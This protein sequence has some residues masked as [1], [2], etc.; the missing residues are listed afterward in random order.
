MK[1]LSVRGNPLIGLYAKVSENFAVIGVSD[2]KLESSLRETLGVDVVSTTVAG[3]ELVGAM[4][5]LNS[6]GLVVSNGITTK[7]LERL[8]S[9]VD[10]KIVDTPMTCLGNNFC[11]NDRG[12][13]SHPDLD[14]DIIG[15]VSDF[16]GIEISRGTVGGIKTVGMAAVITNR[17]GIVHPNATEWE[18]KKISKLMGVEALKGTANFGNDMVGSSILANSKGYLVGRDTTGLELGII[19]E[20]LFP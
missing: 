11:V 9:K 15:E 13:I 17:G 14:S 12:G 18:L 2:E 3:S 6:R 19:D 8:R 4:V 16:L 1:L 5:V 10:V 7:E 20:A